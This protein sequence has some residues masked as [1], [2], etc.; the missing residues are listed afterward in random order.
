MRSSTRP[1][2]QAL[3]HRT[4]DYY[5]LRGNMENKQEVV[6]SDCGRPFISSEELCQNCGSLN[7]TINISLEVPSPPKLMLKGKVKDKT[8]PSVKNPRIKFMT[9]DDRR[10]IDGKWMKKRQH[11]NVDLEKYF[12]SSRP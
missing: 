7:K 2:Y 11:I 4:S 12:E 5:V 1:I 3:V 8:H 6:C 10:E 9:G